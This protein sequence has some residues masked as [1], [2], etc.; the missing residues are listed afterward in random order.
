MVA[1]IIPRQPG[2]QGLRGVDPGRYVR[3]GR[4]IQFA[5]ETIAQTG[6][7]ATNYFQ[8]IEQNEAA[9]E[10]SIGFSEK[11]NEI[12]SKPYRSSAE[13]RE[14]GFDGPNL[15][16][17][18]MEDRDDVAVW[19]FAPDLLKQEYDRITEKTAE[20]ISG[21]GNKAAWRS[22]RAIQGQKMY[23][24]MLQ[25]QREA[26]WEDKIARHADA[27]D[28]AIQVRDFALAE[29]LAMSHPD[30]TRR[31][32]TLSAVKVDVEFAMAHN[33][34]QSQDLRQMQE[35][36]DRITDKDYDGVLTEP[37]Q[38]QLGN[39]LRAGISELTQKETIKRLQPFEQM[40][41]A[42]EMALTTNDVARAAQLDAEMQQYLQ[43]NGL[44][45]YV[46]KGYWAK[47]DSRIAEAIL[48]MEENAVSTVG[49][50]N[51]DAMAVDN[52]DGKQTSAIDQEV[53]KVM[54]DPTLPQE[55]VASVVAQASAGARYIPK[56]V[57]EL[58]EDVSSQSVDPQQAL[59]AA[60]IYENIRLRNQTLVTNIPDQT[61]YMMTE[62]SKH[63]KA[64]QPVEDVIDQVRTRFMSADEET[65]K[66]RQNNFRALVNDK[67]DPLGKFLNSKLSGDSWIPNFI[68]GFTFPAEIVPGDQMYTDY[69]KAVEVH[70]A[71]GMDQGDAMQLGLEDFMATHQPS[72]VNGSKEIMR[73]AP[74]AMFGEP[75]EVIQADFKAYMTEHVDDYSPGEYVFYPDAY[76][77]QETVPSYQVFAVENGQLMTVLGDLGPMRYTPNKKRMTQM[78]VDTAREDWQTT[79]TERAMGAVSQALGSLQGWGPTN[80]QERRKI[81]E[82]QQRLGNVEFADQRAKDIKADRV[83]LQQLDNE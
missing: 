76:T 17:E 25:A 11:Y 74:E 70:M 33:A 28:R 41:G 18:D 35:E 16:T 1:Q 21:A 80:L 49:F 7:N 71:G 69:L 46:S 78:R 44:M 68:E 61:R 5:A 6:R 24:G 13:V 75:T 58:F 8:E 2:V 3:E 56:P 47:Q 66:I 12:V 55:Y 79:R 73:F 14:M 9:A 37:Q 32:E 38:T 63:I 26:L 43:A 67:R 34:Y 45:D 59:L 29:T 36:Y 42:Y 81:Q 40:Q 19:E 23:D 64:N 27:I 50:W 30:P 62:I 4:N 82:E 20:R 83:L 48:D 77:D 39:M 60:G 10:A 22:Q 15:L 54:S 53:M 65:L 52:F 51:G 57:L 72:G 31:Q